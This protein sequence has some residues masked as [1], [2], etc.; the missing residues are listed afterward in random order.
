MNGGNGGD[1]YLV[2][3]NG[4]V[5]VENTA[6]AIGGIDQVNSTAGNHTIGLGIENLTL[7]AGAGDGTGNGIA[8]LI[9]GNGLANDLV[10]GGG[11]DTLNGGALAD[12]L[13]GGA[14]A[15]DL[16]GGAG[17]VVDTFDFNSAAESGPAAA[18]RD[19]IIGFNGA[20]APALDLI[21]LDTIDAD[22]TVA[23]DQD[24][25]FLGV[26]QNPFPAPTDAGDLYLRTEGGNT[27]VYGNTDGD[28]DP[29]ASRSRSPTAPSLP[30]PTD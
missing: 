18:Q 10:G 21:N 30:A 23:G 2:D 19:S 14:G 20:G 6:A 3:N 28:D 29:E 22:T 8:N 9:I 24:F 26:I 27:I 13:V 17:A 5:I 16:I 25:T 1:L 4:D 15:D 7:L 12:L 11:A